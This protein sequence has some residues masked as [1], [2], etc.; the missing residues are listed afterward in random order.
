[1]PK[2]GG[3]GSYFQQQQQYGGADRAGFGRIPGFNSP[4]PGGASADGSAL[5]APGAA[6][7]G[8]L[9]FSCILS[10]TANSAS[11]VPLQ[12]AE[13]SAT[14]RG[15]GVLLDSAVIFEVL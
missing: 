14:S 15:P 6:I 7:P 8:G 10:I 2:H 3:A 12:G 11:E 4:V 13:L 5:R 9:S 1:M